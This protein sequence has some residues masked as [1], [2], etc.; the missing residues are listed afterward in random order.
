ML[1]A[2]VT[3]PHQVSEVK[4]CRMRFEKMTYK[5]FTILTRFSSSSQGSY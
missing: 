1:L 5:I 4:L 2:P 3:L